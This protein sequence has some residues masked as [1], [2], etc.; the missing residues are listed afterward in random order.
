LHRAA[1]RRSHNGSVLDTRPE[2]AVRSRPSAP[3]RFSGGFR[4]NHE[5]RRQ[6]RAYEKPTATRLTREQA[7]LKSMGCA[8]IGSKKAREFLE[9]LFK[10]E[11]RSR[12]RDESGESA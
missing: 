11:D 10:V 8:M 5:K 2:M 4:L 1:A 12:A 3:L 7:K 9:L 6:K